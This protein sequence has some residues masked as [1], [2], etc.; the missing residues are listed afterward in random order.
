M[1]SFA[2]VAP[3]QELRRRLFASLIVVVVL[4]ILGGFISY[5]VLGTGLALVLGTLGLILGLF[6]SARWAQR[7]YRCPACQKL[8][9]KVEVRAW[10]KY[11]RYLRWLQISKRFTVYPNWA[12]L[13]IDFN[14]ARCLSCGSVLG[15]RGGEFIGAT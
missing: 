6:L 8:P 9:M 14:P 13:F 4:S 12:V 15:R 1:D 2:F 5:R 7:T 3:F 10:T 11:T